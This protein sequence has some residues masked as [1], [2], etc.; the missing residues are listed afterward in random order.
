MDDIQQ[1]LL[2]LIASLPAGTN[3]YEVLDEYLWGIVV[4]DLPDSFRG[5]LLFLLV[6]FALCLILV[7]GSLVVRLWQ[8]SFWVVHLGTSPKLI[9]P[10]FSVSWSLW[11]A[12][13]LVL[14]LANSA[15]T[16]RYYYGGRTVRKGFIAWKTLVWLPAWYGGFTA[17]W[18]I[19]VSYLLH[20]HT[21]GHVEAVECVA[22]TVNI[23]AFVVPVIYTIC[24]VPFAGLAAHH[25][26]RAM[27]SFEQIDELLKSSAAAYTGVFNITDLMGGL[28]LVQAM[29]SEFNGF[30]KWFRVTFAIYAASGFL[31]VILLASVALLYLFSLRDILNLADNISR[32]T[33]GSRESRRKLMSRT[34][35]NLV[36]T[37]IAFSLL[38]L[39]FSITC[40]LI[41][42]DPAGLANATRTQVFHLLPFYAFAVLGLP[43]A[44]L[45][46][47]RSFDRSSSPP[48]AH[49]TTPNN[50]GSRP[51]VGGTSAGQVSVSVH[52]VSLVEPPRFNTTPPA[53][54]RQSS[55]LPYA[56]ARAAFA[57]PVPPGFE[58]VEHKDKEK[59]DSSST[60]EDEHDHGG[61]GVEVMHVVPSPGFAPESP[62][63]GR[64]SYA[65][66]TG[67]C[68]SSPR[69]PASR[70]FS[71]LS[72]S[73]SLS[74]ERGSV[75][76]YSFGATT[77]LDSPLTS[78]SR[79]GRVRPESAVMEEQ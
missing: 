74:A 31:L 3:P 66:E 63:V 48:R 55:L 12:I 58:M 45:L 11:A 62:V 39:I 14:M 36:A 25:F 8:K 57:M 49:S 65:A 15:E 67:S 9:R 71:E 23:C 22:P 18:S 75:A 21:Y 42:N 10:H 7:V 38:G 20:L 4:P 68:F 35:S 41:A 46:F 40:I 1:E 44:T 28:P 70:P 50:N 30:I 79:T 37:V 24:I 72:L 59:Y 26:S 16:I 33:T 32:S 78:P 5:Q 29:S 69:Q 73:D 47:V 34:Y 51:S 64:W 77:R 60:T 54:S 17:A 56:H 19:A 13:L 6:V 2:E 76:A 27:D 61:N 52:V 53:H 43:T